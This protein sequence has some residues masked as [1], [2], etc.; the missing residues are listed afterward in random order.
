MLWIMNEIFGLKEIFGLLLCCAWGKT[1]YG[2]A[3]N[4]CFWPNEARLLK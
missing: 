1:D 3:Y 4:L 2:L